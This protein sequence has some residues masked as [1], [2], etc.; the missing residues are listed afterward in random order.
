MD[1]Q[2]VDDVVNDMEPNDEKYT[3]Q[4]SRNMIK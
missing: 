2:R 3:K 4:K 1:G